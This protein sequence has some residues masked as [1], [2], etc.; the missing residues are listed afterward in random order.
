MVEA[1]FPNIRPMPHPQ[2]TRLKL[3]EMLR[4][5]T[6]LPPDVYDNLPDAIRWAT[7]IA[8]QDPWCPAESRALLVRWISD[9]SRM[10]ED[11]RT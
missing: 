2:D 8:T 10:L 1:L 5:G 7:E 11:L 4:S 9:A 6:Y 3:S